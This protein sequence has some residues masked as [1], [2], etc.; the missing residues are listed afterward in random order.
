MDYQSHT[1]TNHE[2]IRNW[3]EERK[4]VPATVKGTPEGGEDAG[5]LRIDF[6]DYSPDP[7]LKHI[8]WNEFFEKFDEQHLSFLYQNEQ[9]EGGKSRFNKFVYRD[10]EGS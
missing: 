8:H 10:R 6:P 7:S 3:V 2:V 9:K 1:T 5:L 4:G